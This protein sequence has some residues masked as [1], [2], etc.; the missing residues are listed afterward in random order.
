VT[1]EYFQERGWWTPAQIRDSLLDF[2]LKLTTDVVEQVKLLAQHENERR[3]KLPDQYIQCPHCKGFHEQL[4][5]ID[6]LCEKHEAQLAPF[7]YD[8]QRGL[9]EL[10][11][12][13]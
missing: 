4:K 9:G 7:R 11:V 2:N 8:S 1:P 10:I 5:N 12:E 13:V 6:G 3:K